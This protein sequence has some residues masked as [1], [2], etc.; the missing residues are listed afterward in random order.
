MQRSARNSGGDNMTRAVH[1][2][3]RF[4]RLVAE[5]HASTALEVLRTRIRSQTTF[6][7]LLRDLDIPVQAPPARIPV[8][9]R[10]LSP[11]DDLS[12]LDADPSLDREANWL[13]QEQR[14]LADAAIPTCWVAI[15]E[16]NRVAYMQ[17]LIA[18]AHNARIREY[19]DDFFPQLR[20][21]EALL[22]GAYT[23]E[24]FRGQGIM[25]HA[26]ARISEAARESGARH[27]ITFV[28]E[29]NIPALKG[30]LKA[31]FSPHLMRRHSWTM[32]RRRVEF[33]ELPPDMA[34]SFEQR[35]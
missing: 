34:L 18:S 17:W 21:H 19:W 3:R 22:E 20:P 26:M 11:D 16:G 6:Y 10:P 13:R 9:V 24:A 25:P 5:G 31:G 35:A 23:P 1:R 8:E 7:G 30:S 33:S 12:F 28:K 15:A 14:R 29:G 32:L 2:A 4:V 27:V